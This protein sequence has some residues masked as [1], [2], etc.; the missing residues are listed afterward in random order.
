MTAYDSYR[1]DLAGV[2]LVTVHVASN[3]TIHPSPLMCDYLIEPVCR[4]RAL[5][6]PGKR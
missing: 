6:S 4:L 3:N 5:T 2:D 1:L